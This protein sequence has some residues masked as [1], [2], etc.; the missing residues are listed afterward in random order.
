[1]ISNRLLN[2]FQALT[3][4]GQRFG[5]FVVGFDSS[6]NLFKISTDPK[7][8]RITKWK[9]WGLIFWAVASSSTLCKF[10]FANDID[11][12][13]ITLFFWLCGLS[14]LIIYSVTYWFPES[15]CQTGNMTFTFLKRIHGNFSKLKNAYI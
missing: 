13:N 11:K 12:Y 14:Q 2:L 8:I 6:L 9:Y 15:F 3:N 1:M 7:V 10:Y 4:Y 5:S